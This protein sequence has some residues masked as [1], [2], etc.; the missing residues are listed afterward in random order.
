MNDNEKICDDYHS[1]RFL[2]SVLLDEFWMMNY[3]S[4]WTFHQS[5]GNNT[6]Q[7]QIVLL[8]LP[9][10]DDDLWIDLVHVIY[11]S[12]FSSFSNFR[13]CDSFSFYWIFH[14]VIPLLLTMMVLPH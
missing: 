1:M 13:V 3:F 7:S 2:H 9:D 5:K 12:L 11:L 4:Y 6:V 14:P 10:D 8:E